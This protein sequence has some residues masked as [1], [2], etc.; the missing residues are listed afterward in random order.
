MAYL[1]RFSCLPQ[2]LKFKRLIDILKP[3]GKKIVPARKFKKL[4][5]TLLRFTQAC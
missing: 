1:S 2:I 4:F 3:H 5:V